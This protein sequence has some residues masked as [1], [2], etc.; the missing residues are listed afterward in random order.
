MG[1]LG[2]VWALLGLAIGLS[3]SGLVLN[4][5]AQGLAKQVG[6]GNRGP[7]TVEDV[8]ED[9]LNYFNAV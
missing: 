5:F 3:T 6:R 4:I 2:A 7:A 8:W 9:S 1:V